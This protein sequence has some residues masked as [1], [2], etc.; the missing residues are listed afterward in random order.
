MCPILNFFKQRRL[1]LNC[2]KTN[3]I[4]FSSSRS[5]I[6]MDPV[7]KISPGQFIF[8]VSTTKYLG[9]V[10]DENLSWSPHIEQLEKKFAPVNG[11]LWKHRDFLPLRARKLVYDALFLI[12][13]HLGGSH[14]GTLLPT[15]RFFKIVDSGTFT[16]SPRSQTE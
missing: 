7:I 9:L 2:G 8:R 4:L 5:R 13:G 16:H 11:M 3:F 10:L 1:I 15:S 6:S 12:W 14:L